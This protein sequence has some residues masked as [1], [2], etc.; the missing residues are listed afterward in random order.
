MGYFK[1]LFKLNLPPTIIEHTIL[2]L[3]VDNATAHVSNY[4]FADLY[5]FEPG[6]F[7]VKLE[8][9][10]MFKIASRSLPIW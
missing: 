4:P 7:I 3:A 2:P 9:T 8:A 1:V 10:M 6:M 5:A